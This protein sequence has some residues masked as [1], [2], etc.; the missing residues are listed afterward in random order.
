MVAFTLDGWTS[1]FQMSFLAITAHW[2]NDDWEQEDIT[3]GFEQLKGPHTGEALMDA[4]IIV[5][6]RFNLQRK[7]MSITS[8]N[9]SNVLKLTSLF[10]DY[11]RQNHNAW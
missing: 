11:T 5:V 7:V 4:F 3:I 6:E 2:I 9:G 8:D 1:P 10:E